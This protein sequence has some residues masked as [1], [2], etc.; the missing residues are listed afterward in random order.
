LRVLHGHTDEIYALAWGALG[1]RPVLASA[2]ADATVRLWDPAD[3]TPLRTIQCRHTDGVWAVAWGALTTGVE[4]PE[5]GAAGSPTRAHQGVS[6][7]GT[8]GCAVAVLASAGADDTIR[9]WDPFDGTQL[10]VLHGHTGPVNALAFGTLD[11][12][13]LLASAGRDGTVRLW[14]LTHQRQAVLYFDGPVHAVVIG[15]HGRLAVAG[16]NGV[17]VLLVNSTVFT[18]AGTGVGTRR[19]L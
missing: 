18:N 19:A 7:L 13:T 12:A 2:G 4:P 5:G 1:G 17:A 8:Q 16:W 14:D 9:L 6:P 11:G 3:G 10:R 15:P